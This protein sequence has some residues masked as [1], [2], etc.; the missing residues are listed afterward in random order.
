MWKMLNSLRWWINS[1]KREHKS[2]FNSAE[3]TYMTEEDGLGN[4]TNVP[5]NHKYIIVLIWCTIYAN[6]LCVYS[7]V[8]LECMPDRWRGI[9]TANQY[10][11]SSIAF[12]CLSVCS[13][14]TP[15]KYWPKH[16]LTL[17]DYREQSRKY[18]PQ[19]KIATGRL[20]SLSNKTLY[21]SLQS[22][23]IVGNDK[24]VQPVTHT[25]DKAT[26]GR[27]SWCLHIIAPN[28]AEYTVT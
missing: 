8:S 14:Q 16:W 20:H 24:H 18:T 22:I 11:Y 26:E 12:V 3:N 7:Q 25:A 21:Q 27:R 15:P 13:L 1:W 4:Y 23:V 2:T 19:F 17:R 28:F 6:Q 5:A 10:K 9:T